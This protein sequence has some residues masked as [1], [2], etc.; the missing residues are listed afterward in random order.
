M[1][2]QHDL[3]DLTEYGRFYLQ[4]GDRQPAHEWLTVLKTVYSNNIIHTLPKEK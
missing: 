2:G 1:D 4:A 3:H